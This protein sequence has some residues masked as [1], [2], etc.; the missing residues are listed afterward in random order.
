MANNKG[1]H[2]FRGETILPTAIKG[3][4]AFNGTYSSCHEKHGKRQVSIR[5]KSESTD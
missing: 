1:W 5:E 2:P 4:L 3:N